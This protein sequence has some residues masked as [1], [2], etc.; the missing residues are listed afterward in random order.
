MGSVDKCNPKILERRS[1]RISDA[2]SVYNH[3]LIKKNQ[4]YSLDKC[5]S[6]EL[7]CLQIS[8]NN[9]KTR[10]QLYFEDLFQIKDID[11]K[12]VYLLPRR[13]TVDT[14]LRIFQYKILNNVLYLN[15]NVFRFKKISYPL[16]SFY[17][18][19][20]ETPI[21][22]FHGCIKTN[23][24]WYKLKKIMKAK[25]DLP[26]NTP[27]SAIFG[28]LNYENNS[29]IIKYYLFNS[30]EHKK[31]SLEVLIKEIVKICNIEKQICFKDFKK[32]KKLWKKWEIIGHS[33]Q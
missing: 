20:N 14:N 8:L 1:N 3:N 23:L 18:S 29:D 2:L 26:V 6:K 15:E 19:E 13:V 24:L 21:H 9:S 31:L 32:T 7:E 17:Q 27:Q 28:F 16:C 4:I 5:N 30:S 12:H 10:S 25:I 33:L 11:W 22:L